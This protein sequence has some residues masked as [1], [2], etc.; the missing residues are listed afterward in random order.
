MNFKAVSDVLR[1]IETAFQLENTEVPFWNIINGPIADALW[2]CG[3]VVM[4]RRA[5]GNPF[6]AKV[7]VFKGKVSD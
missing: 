1:R 3:Q 4:L 5:S 6:N 7:N 2:H